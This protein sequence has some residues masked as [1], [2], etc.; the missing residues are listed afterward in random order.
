[1][2][3]WL[4][5]VLVDVVAVASFARCFTGPGELTA[6]LVTL[7]AAQLVAHAAGSVRHAR[8]TWA[9]AVALAVLV[10]LGVVL[11]PT[12]FSHGPGPASWGVLEG[13]LRAA[14]RAF[15]FKVAP[16][17]ELPGLVLATALISG[18][19]GLV[20]ELIF[21]KRKI[22]A[23]FALLPAVTVYLFACSLGTGAWR[24]VGLGCMAG[25]A[26]LYLVA[27]A[28]ERE[29]SSTVVALADNG[30]SPGRRSTSYR[31]AATMLRLVVLAAVAA[32]VVGPNLPGARSAALVTWRGLGANSG[33][34]GTT[35]SSRTTPTAERIGIST[36]VQVEEE[37]VD[38][39]TVSLFSVHSAIPTRE[40]IATLDEFNGNRWSASSAASTT[41]GRFA[42][43]LGA[44]EQRPVA[45]A[46]DGSGRSKLVQV[47]DVSQL[48][49]NTLPA[50][51]APM[52]VDGAGQ[53]HRVG[54][55]GPVVSDN[56]LE[57]GFVYAVSSVIADPST[58]E[59]AGASTDTSE[60]RYLQLPPPPQRLVTLAH[61]LVAGATSPYQK[62]LDLD[63]Y[64][65]SARFH[66]KLPAR[67]GPGTTARAGYGA[68][69]QFL[70]AARTGYCQ[71]FATAFAVLAR[72][73][74]LPTRIAVGFLTG[75]PIGHD[76]W[77]VDGNDT[78]AW[79]QVLFARYGWIDFEPTPGTA[80]IGAS[81]PSV[82]TTT[83]P[84]GAGV[85]STTVRPARNLSKPASPGTTGSQASSR[86]SGGF[87]TIGLLW[88]F[89][90]LSGLA[91]VAGVL[92]WRRSRLRRAATEPRAGVLVAW[93]E[94]SRMLDLA[95]VRR[96][97]AETFV[98]L[99]RRV[100]SIGLLSSEAELALGDLAR[101]ATTACYSALP[102]SDG[103]AKKALADATIVVG[104]ARGRVA[105]WLIVAAALDPRGLLL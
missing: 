60:R 16:V 22:P 104:S 37:E 29:S 15:Y 26:C 39:P 85:T 28:R 12:V 82:S 92:L 7:L 77:Q 78:H 30:L 49:G 43:S 57:P 42:T 67:L 4:A 46:P 5:L 8:R 45:P 50:W 71:Q 98:E 76:T 21:A 54:L 102:P 48:G 91:W 68:L 88:L 32:A 69:I 20:A 44:D 38:D 65:T 24:V 58:A 27:A 84:V 61:S 96:R 6:A 66:Y 23:V 95:G 53:V 105:R 86:G 101:L 73:D 81:G 10:P 74:G 31:A 25:S 90:P 41:L 35:V 100:S 2:S 70:F 93:G 51:G 52:A 47:F 11:G 83:S 13:D 14:W 94:A 99:A 72:I 75:V 103:A 33:G 40:M 36:L 1:V 62:A 80:V 59:L 87:G 3:A 97:R 18:V 34:T 55:G 17:A 19:L 64:L 79:P 63:A 56:A 9:L 89:V